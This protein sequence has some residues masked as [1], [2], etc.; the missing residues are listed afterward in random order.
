MKIHKN[1]IVG[2]GPIG[3]HVFNKFSKCSLLITGKTKRLIYSRNLHP[4][5]KLRLNKITNKFSDL[6]FS[7][8]NNFCIYSSSEMGG[9]SNYWGKQFFDY[10]KKDL[11]PKEIFKKYSIYKKNL[12]EIDNIYLCPKYEVIKNIIKKDLIFNQIKPPILKIPLINRNNLIKKAKKKILEDR[13][14]SFNKIKK[15][16][17]M[18]ITENSTLYCRNLV[19]CA[20]PIG[21]A[22][23]LIRSFK[24]INYLTFKDDNPRMIFG[25]KFNKKD[26]LSKGDENLADV[27]II[28]NGNLVN[29]CTIYNVNP[30][31]FN[32]FFK[33]IIFFLK[34]I[35]TNFFFYGQYWVAGEYNEIKIKNA[36][37]KIVVSGKTKNSNIYKINIIKNLN[38]IGLKVIKILNLK[39]AF[40]FHYH[41]LKVKYEGK[42][43]TLNQFINKQNLS[44]NVYCFDSSVIAK[45]GLKPPTKTYLATANYLMKKFDNK[46]RLHL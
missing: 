36:S 10:Q 31:H 38:K 29:Y 8:K 30:L 24:R 23:I 11:W 15:N 13:V 27:D 34:N 46:L 22:M 26:T 19:L 28:K 42:L 44:N 14:I 9:F 40:G 16:L 21:N 7:K 37:N 18:V 17:I 3:C 6:F 45:I 32:K 5:I 4:K 33:S 25:F 2:G 43:F 1:I 12:N 35:L 39:F 20:G 41:C